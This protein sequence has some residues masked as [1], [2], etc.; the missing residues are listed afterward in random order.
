MKINIFL[1]LSCVLLS[2]CAKKTYV[3]DSQKLFHQFKNATDSLVNKTS[4]ITDKTV[5]FISRSIDTNIIITG[6]VLSGYLR[7]SK[8][9]RNDTSAYFENEDL[10]LF[11]RI[12][13]AGNASAT[14][15]PKTKTI[16]AKAFEQKAV[17]ND[18]EKRD[19]AN[20]HAKNDLEV[21][22]S[23]AA[24]HTQKETTGN[25]S[26]SLGLVVVLLLACVFIWIAR[27]FNFWGKL[28]G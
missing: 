21:R 17:Y 20:M 5:T 22:T 27:K 11:L 23:L 7:P 6:K 14:A 18:V 3:A 25:A 9:R 28:F 1:L 8:L 26:F 15:I 24:K 12:N 16:S 13:R 2:S 19:A 4:T 10:T